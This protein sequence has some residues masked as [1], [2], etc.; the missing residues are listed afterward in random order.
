M[1]VEYILLWLKSLTMGQIFVLTGAGILLA[2]TGLAMLAHWIF[3]K[4]NKNDD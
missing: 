4:D 2:G 1:S 3:E